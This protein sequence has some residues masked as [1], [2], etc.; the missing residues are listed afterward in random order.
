[1]IDKGI[2]SRN[3][4][5]FRPNYIFSPFFPTLCAENGMP[6]GT[7]PIRRATRDIAEPM[8]FLIFVPI[9][10]TERG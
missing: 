2:A 8:K 3:L 7:Y 6:E 10:Q 1:M 4:S 9:N 5:N